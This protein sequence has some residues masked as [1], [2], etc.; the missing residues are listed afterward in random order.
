[1]KLV[2]EVSLNL[3]KRELPLVYYTDHDL[4]LAPEEGLLVVL[5]PKSGGTIHIYVLSLFYFYFL[6]LYGGL[7]FLFLHFIVS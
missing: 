1:M 3:I 7:I 2:V 4:K 6:F 5:I